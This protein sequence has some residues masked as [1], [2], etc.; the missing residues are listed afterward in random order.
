MTLS[1]EGL[2]LRARTE[3]E[4]AERRQASRDS[5]SRFGV[6]TFGDIA[7]IEVGTTIWTE[8]TRRANSHEEGLGGIVLDIIDQVDTDDETGEVTRRRA[9]RC[10]DPAARWDK[11][12]RVF[13]E[14]EISRH[15]MEMTEPSSL[16]NAVRK[17]CRTVGAR[18]GLL[19]PRDAELVSDAARL[20]S[21]LMAGGW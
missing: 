17:F 14:A 20:A 21:T 16:V 6:R 7:L 9:F 1:P 8:P 5:G 11:A 4:A 2:A 10:Y 15:G 12:F 13:G 19:M 18:H 3:A